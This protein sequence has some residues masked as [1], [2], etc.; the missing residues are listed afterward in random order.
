[1]PTALLGRAD[2]PVCTVKARSVRLPGSCAVQSILGIVVAKARADKA[3]RRAAARLNCDAGAASYERAAIGPLFRLLE[4]IVC[5]PM[6]EI[7][8][9][10][11]N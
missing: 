7:P 8:I 4:A 5:G 1:M 6:A 10:A 3:P 2:T 11:S 9:K